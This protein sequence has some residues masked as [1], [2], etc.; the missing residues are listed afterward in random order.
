MKS[1]N[2]INNKERDKQISLLF[3]SLFEVS[4]EV[5]MVRTLL[6]NYLI[7]KKDVK[8]FTKYLQEQEEKRESEARKAQPSKGSGASKASGKPSKAL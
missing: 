6:E 1:K 5:R 4:Q 7:W 8:K 2:K 3:Q